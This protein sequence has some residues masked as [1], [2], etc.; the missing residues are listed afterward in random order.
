MASSLRGSTTLISL[1]SSNSMT[2]TSSSDR[3]GRAA[4]MLGLHRSKIGLQRSWCLTQQRWA[5]TRQRSSITMQQRCF[6]PLSHRILLAHLSFRDAFRLELVANKQIT[7]FIL[8]ILRSHPDLR[9]GNEVFMFSRQL[10]TLRSIS[11]SSLRWNFALRS[12]AT[13]RSEQSAV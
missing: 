9:P 2:M 5:Y 4:T 6:L 13:M 3:A 1:S 12:Y 11:S 10:V 7:N 8:I